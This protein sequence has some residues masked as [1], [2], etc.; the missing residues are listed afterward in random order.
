[1]IKVND[2]YDLVPEIFLADS[3]FVHSDQADIEVLPAMCKES[4]QPSGKLTIFIQPEPDMHCA[5]QLYHRQIAARPNAIWA[6]SGFDNRR[7]WKLSQWILHFSN[8]TMTV[9][10]NPDVP[11]V[12]PGVKPYLATA[13]LGGWMQHRG[14]IMHEL[15]KS[16]LIDQCLASYHSRSVMSQEQKTQWQTQWP[17]FMIDYRSPALD[18]YEHP[19]FKQVAFR[20][21]QCNA[22]QPIPLN[23]CQ[24][25]PGMKVH[26]HGWISQLVPYHIYNNAYIS[27]VAETECAPCPNSFFVSEKIVRPMLVAQPFV[28][29]GCQY[30][31]KYLRELGFRTFDPVLDESYDLI[32]NP[33]QRARAMVAS[34]IKFS[35]QSHQQRAQAVAD[36]RSAADH[37]RKL[38]L[39]PTWTTHTL[40]S[41]MIKHCKS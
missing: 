31:L 17:D 9:R 37:N 19:V 35:A 34:V 12:L 27:I 25:I 3:N 15:K 8:L 30:Y 6:V 10:V 33:D 20:D 28:I 2:V 5:D 39:D 22:L 38:L 1:M 32:A 41:A 7:S 14:M 4:F 36:M 16:N 18:Q 29:F 24:P 26:Q 21:Q 23:T 40:R 13:L 11:A